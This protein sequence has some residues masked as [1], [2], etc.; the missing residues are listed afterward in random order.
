MTSTH[1]QTNHACLS[2]GSRD[3]YENRAF[4]ALPRVTS[5]SVPFPAGGGICVCLQCGLIQKITDDRWKQEIQ[6]IYR[7]YNMY[8]LTDGSDQVLFHEGG[9][10][11]AEKI[12]DILSPHL[13][14]PFA[15]SVIDIGCGT[16]GFLKAF[17]A[18]FPAAVLCGREIS[19]KNRHYLEQIPNFSTL[20][21][22]DTP[23]ID[24]KFDVI[25]SIH[26]FEHLY[27]YA[28]FFEEIETIRKDGTTLL[29]QVPDI[30]SSPFDLVIA[31]HA[32]HF[33]QA[34]FQRCLNRSL[35][36]VAVSKPIH[37][38]LTALAPQASAGEAM[39]GAVSQAACIRTLDTH[40]DYLTK[41]LALIDGHHL[42]EFGVYGTTIAGAWLTGAY[43]DK[44]AFYVDDDP[45][46]QGKTFYNKSIISADQVQ[47]RCK[48]LLPFGISTVRAIL[49]R[50]PNLLPLAIYCD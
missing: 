27:D 49:N 41:L 13:E 36:N 35:K 48:V 33:S 24:R 23:H 34:T 7:D 32:A 5:D 3:V 20:F 31:D 45:L 39:P 47:N 6:A 19:D 25:T 40:V 2:C 15:G 50:H 28:A 42:S 8:A 29:L 43:G 1:E 11:R 9:V 26:C 46:K 17:G 37:K 14:K 21:T 12:V 10:T 18:T 4:R 16:G 22:A 38:E 44:I 30:D